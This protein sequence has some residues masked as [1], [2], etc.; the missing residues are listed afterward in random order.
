[1]FPTVIPHG[2]TARRL[3]WAH[4]PPPVRRAVE[5][6]LG[7]PVV[8]AVSQDAGFTPGF[9]STLTGAD[10]AQAFVKAAATRAQRAV[11]DAYREE[12][13]KLAALPAAAPAPRLLWSEDVA[14]WFVL[15]IEYVDA[16]APHRPW[17]ADDL[18]AASSMAVEMARTL[19]PA[20]TGLADSAVEDFAPW[21]TL[22]ERLDHPRAREIRSLAEGYPEVV[23]G[24][25][26][27]HTDIRDDNI[28]LRP[29]GSALLCDWSWPTVG[30]AWL[31]SLLLLIGPRGDGLDVEA[32][33]AAHPLLS[34]VPA[35]H[36]DVVLALVLGYFAASAD[37]PV[38][39]TSPYLRAAQAWQRDVVDDWLGERRGWR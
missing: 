1:M 32:H 27:V 22:W 7:S 23:A 11:A 35:E 38:P 4:L 14:D 2:R 5:R 17:R 9:A 24:G 26:L 39:P 28:L 10:G 21:P 34:T 25:T 8:A 30:A 18:A 13:R 20:P 33:I 12:A 3:D 36:V 19:T 37:L 6:R 16:R 31:D 29:D 15:A